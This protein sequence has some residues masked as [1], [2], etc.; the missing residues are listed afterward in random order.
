PA[1]PHR[2]AQGGQV[3][4]AEGQAVLVLEGQQ[5]RVERHPAGERLGAVDRVEDPAP[6]GG[7][8][9]GR[10]L[11]AEHPV[12][13]EVLGQ[14]LAQEPLG[15]AV[16]GGDRRAV[17]LADHL[18]VVA[19]EP[20]QGAVAGLLDEPDGEV[21]GGLVD[22]RGRAHPAESGPGPPREPP[23]SALVPCAGDLRPW[24]PAAGAAILGWRA[25]PEEAP[26]PTGAAGADHHGHLPAM[27]MTLGSGL[28][29]VAGVLTG[30]PG[31]VALGAVF[32]AALGLVVG[33]A[34]DA[35]S[36]RRG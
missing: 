23:R 17:L 32:G 19:P 10:L 26:M 28:G 30:G 9:G 2:L 33:S 24:W 15:V 5:V 21:E 8:V 35:L 36:A 34:I 13:G 1:G 29:M 3:D 31:A 27:G 18:E 4:D 11:L 14:L 12:A 6:P 20:A 25:E 7:G 16:G 22:G